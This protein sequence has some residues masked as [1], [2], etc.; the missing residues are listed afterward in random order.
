MEGAADA[1]IVP[2]SA[3][4][5]AIAAIDDD[6]DGCVRVAI[7]EIAEGDDDASPMFGSILF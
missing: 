5:T 6:D 4:A 2:S 7:F 3:A 1:F